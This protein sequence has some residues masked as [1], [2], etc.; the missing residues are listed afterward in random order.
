MVHDV[1]KGRGVLS[2]K[3]TTKPTTKSLD[4]TWAF[5]SKY[6]RMGYTKTID[7]LLDMMEPIHHTGKIVLGNSDFCI[8]IGVMAL[9]R[10]GIHGQFLIMKW[11]YWTKN[12][13]VNYIDGYMATKPLG[14]M[15]T[16]V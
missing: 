13:P 3:P 11:K 7:L 16:F 4:G 10:F 14:H 6:K 15:E 2:S 5:P 12:V 9:P 8:V 1:S